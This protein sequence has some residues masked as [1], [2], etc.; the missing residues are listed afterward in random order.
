MR[1]EEAYNKLRDGIVGK[2]FN[3]IFSS[4]DLIRNKGKVGQLVEKFLGISPGNRNLDFVDGELKTFKCKA[5]CKVN[6]IEV[7]GTEEEESCISPKETLA[8]TQISTNNIADYLSLDFEETGLYKK[9]QRILFVPVNKEAREEEWYIPSVKLVAT[10][11]E[12]GKE[13]KE[14]FEYIISEIKRMDKIK[15]ITGPNKYLQIRSKDSQPYKPIFFNGK[16]LSNK[17]YA[18]YFKKEFIQ[19]I[20]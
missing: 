9:I 4:D 11:Q 7:D 17:N 3:E 13:L 20:F 10:T 2:K 6:F 12:Y 16:Q 8:I 19:E 18:F 14:D 1:I 15:T 5:K